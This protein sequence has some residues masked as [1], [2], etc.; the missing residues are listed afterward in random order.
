MN[1]TRAGLIVLLLRN[2]HVLE[3][4]K[5]GQNRAANPDRV[6]ALWRGNDLDLDAGWS[7]GPKFFLHAVS[8]AREHGRSPGQNDVAEELAADVDIASGDGVVAISI[9]Q[10][11]L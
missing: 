1:D 7:K 11:Y 2:P 4:A 6:L 9:L 5:R 8:N 3:G 10:L